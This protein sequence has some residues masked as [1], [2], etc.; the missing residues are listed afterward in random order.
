MQRLN[1]PPPPQACRTNSSANDDSTAKA[2]LEERCLV[3]QDPLYQEQ[4]SSTNRNI[5]SARQNLMRLSLSGGGY[6]KMSSILADQ[7]SALV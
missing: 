5:R 2:E 4:N 7:F 1:P 6:K 3:S